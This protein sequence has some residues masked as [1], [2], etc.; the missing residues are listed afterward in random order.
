MNKPNP[1]ASIEES[2]AQFA[3][4]RDWDQFHTPKNLILAATAE[5]GELAEVLQW[6]SDE[7][8]ASFLKSD[9]GKTK[10][11]EEVADVV[12]YLIRLC[13]KSEISLVNA[14]SDKLLVNSKKY[15]IDLSRGNSKKY[16]ER[17]ND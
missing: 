11:S 2:V 16:S 13:Q 1:L 6:K 7:E 3:R 15:P 10:L 5:M 17:S 14:I 8:V 9:E 12:I 4:D